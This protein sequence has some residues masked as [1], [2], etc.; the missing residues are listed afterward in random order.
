MPTL[1]LL[2]KSSLSLRTNFLSFIQDPLEQFEV[3]SIFSVCGFVLLNNLEVTWRVIATI[4]F[5]LV[6]FFSLSTA[7]RTG[8]VTAAV[9][10]LVKSI[11]QENLYIKKQQHFPVIFFLFVTIFLSN[12]AGLIPFTFTITSSFG[13]TLFLALSH[14][15]GVNLIGISRHKWGFRNLF[16][17]AGVPLAITPFLIVIE[18]ISYVARVLSL[19]IR[20]FANRRSGHALL[21]IL[22][23]FSLA[24]ASSVSLALNLT[25]VLPWT[26]VTAVRFL[27]LLIA[28]LQAYVFSI[29]VSLYVNDNINSSH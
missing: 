19:S 29:L 9:H 14:F 27:E 23:G 8:F 15:I 28:F 4:A 24:R 7:T 3:T 16:L 6:R 18:V 21:K 20:L 17:P 25:S 13:V 10:T 26:I 22:I 12:L 2:N 5:R 11:V 1:T